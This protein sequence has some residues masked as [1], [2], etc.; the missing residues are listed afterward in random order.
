MMVIFLSHRR[1]GSI[2]KYGMWHLPGCL[3]S[4][5]SVWNKRQMKEREREREMYK[6]LYSL[7]PRTNKRTYKKEN[8]CYSSSEAKKNNV[9]ALKLCWMLCIKKTLCYSLMCKDNKYSIH[10]HLTFFFFCT[11]SMVVLYL[12]LQGRSI[13]VC[14]LSVR[15]LI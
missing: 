2:L 14:F 11:F 3:L 4:R 9:R 7:A 10:K 8:I 6:Y 12:F 15:F 5:C 1:V 13:M